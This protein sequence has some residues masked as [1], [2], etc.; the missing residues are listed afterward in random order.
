V[1]L[2]LAE[3]LL[4][5]VIVPM[6]V[7]ATSFFSSL[8]I[9][10]FNSHEQTRTFFTFALFSYFRFSWGFF[11]AQFDWCSLTDAGGLGIHDE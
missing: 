7:P 9:S 3:S 10:C 6:K 1:A 2:P 11:V 5:G 4:L 8:S